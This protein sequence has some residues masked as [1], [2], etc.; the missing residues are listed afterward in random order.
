MSI[1]VAIKYNNGV[2]IGADTQV[3][4]SNTKHNSFKKIYK[5]KYS[6]TA[7]G[8]VGKARDI[9]LISCNVDDLLDYPDILEK[10]KLDKKYVVNQ[11]V[12]KIFDILMK[13]NR[14]YRID[15][16][17]DIDS[18]FII[19]DSDKIFEIC[20]DGAVVEYDKFCAIGCGSQLA[21]GYLDSINLDG[22]SRLEAEDLIQKVIKDACKNDCY[23]DDNVDII[24][25]E[26]P[27]R[28]K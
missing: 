18:R 5:S 1:V 15:N 12:I 25:L 24:V 14:A 7:W 2:V 11:I 27:K 23:I 26:K 20:T 22:L 21:Q 16:I 3:T 8:G 19:T 9:D 4:F 28:S 17:V 6:N 10:V 13:Y